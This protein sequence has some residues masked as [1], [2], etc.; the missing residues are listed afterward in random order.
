MNKS[1]TLIIYGGILVIL[2]IAAITGWVSFARYKTSYNITAQ[3]YHEASSDYETSIQELRAS[4]EGTENKRVDAENKLESANETILQLQN[5]VTEI[6][7]SLDVK[8]E[9]YNNLSIKYSDLGRETRALRMQVYNFM[10]YETV[11]NVSYSGNTR[12]SSALEDFIESIRGKPD[13]ATWT[14]VWNNSD[15]SIHLILTTEDD[16]SLIGDRFLVYFEEKNFTHP[17]IFWFNEQ[18]WLDKP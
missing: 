10:C 18:C 12:M 8:Q 11:E 13:N 15:T 1:R 4:Q 9:K 16:G 3:A 2:L 14:Q 17:G 5:T 7:D 6:E